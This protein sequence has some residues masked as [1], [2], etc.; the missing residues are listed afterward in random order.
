MFGRQKQMIVVLVLIVF[1]VVIFF[2][3]GPRMGSPPSDKDIKKPPVAEQALPEPEPL[4]PETSVS[5]VTDPQATIPQEEE[6]PAAPQSIPSPEVAAA[7][8]EPPASS[9][10]TAEDSTPV[11]RLERTIPDG[12]YTPGKPLDVQVGVDYPVEATP[13]TAVAV[14]ERL[15]HGWTFGEVTSEEK[16][17]I[18]PLEGERGAL[19]FVWINTPSFPFELTYT[20]NVP[21]SEGGGTREIRGRT[22][23]RTDGPQAES[24]QENT[25]VPP[26]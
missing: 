10:L 24:N 22:V 16:P 18:F 14:V 11:M 4:S 20:A 17:D 21:P 2:V 6:K 26:L 12:G 13:V 8:K 5:D 3:L 15:P 19:Q 25:D 7:P 9:Q 23:Y 1:G